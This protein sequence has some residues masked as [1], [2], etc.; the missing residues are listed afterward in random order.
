MVLVGLFIRK[1]YTPSQG[2][3]N[4]NRREPLGFKLLRLR[5]DP[6]STLQLND[7]RFSGLKTTDRCSSWEFG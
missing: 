6:P 7:A 5:Y 3:D 1:Q 2:S 4:S